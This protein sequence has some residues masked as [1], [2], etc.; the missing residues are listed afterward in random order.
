MFTTPLVR[1]F[2]SVFGPPSSIFD[3]V[4]FFVMA[5]VLKAGHSE[6]RSWFVESLATQTLVVLVIRTRRVPFSRSQ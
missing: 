4:T 6:F 1:G 2:M 3:F 5:V